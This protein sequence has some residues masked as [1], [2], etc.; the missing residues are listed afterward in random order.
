M[1]HE[2]EMA[3]ALRVFVDPQAHGT[4]MSQGVNGRECR[5]GQTGGTPAAPARAN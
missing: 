4:S 5:G 3:A 2:L 1:V